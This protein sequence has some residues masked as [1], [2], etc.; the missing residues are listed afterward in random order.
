MTTRMHVFLP[1][2]LVS[3]LDQAVGK[4]RRSRFVE[5]AIREKL[6]REA[7]GAALRQSAGALDVD[8]YPEW[9]TPEQTSAWVQ[10]QRRQDEARLRRKVEAAAS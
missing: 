4:R 5:E 7:Q 10:E 9:A 1:D 2:D 3:A 8:A 6:A